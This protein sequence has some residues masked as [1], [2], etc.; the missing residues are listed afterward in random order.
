MP[1]ASSKKKVLKADKA[2]IIYQI[3]K[4]RESRNA[5]N[6]QIAEIAKLYG[7]NSNGTRIKRTIIK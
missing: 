1:K 3:L 7:V 4:L 5:T 2:M 6:E